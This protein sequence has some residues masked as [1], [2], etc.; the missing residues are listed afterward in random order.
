MAKL[1][2]RERNAEK[3]RR[4]RER[5]RKKERLTNWYMINLCYG[6]LAIIAIVIIREL[7]Y[8]PSTVLYMQAVT[9][10]ITAVFAAAAILVLVLGMTN[11]IK[12]RT[13]AR[14]YSILLGVCALGSLWLAVYNKIRALSETALRNITGNSSLTI[15]SHW[16]TRILIIAVVLYLII[17]FIYYLIKL[18]RV[19]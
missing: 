1:T 5:A 18:Y 16:N 14:N 10:T 15:N 2:K 9:W 19:K 6:I 3:N 8:T 17:S 11:K 7:Y 4:M 12:N 13:R